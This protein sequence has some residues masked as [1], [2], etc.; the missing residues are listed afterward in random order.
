[1]NLRALIAIA[2]LVAV[3]AVPTAAAGQKAPAAGSKAPV[4]PRRTFSLKNGLRVTLIHTGT[5]K[6]AFV[7][8]VLESGEIDEPAFGPGLASLMADMLLQGTVSR[9]RQAIVTEAA[10]IGTHV[11]VKAGP[12]STTVSAEVDPAN[13]SHLLSLISDIVRHPLLDTASF[14]RAH[15]DAIRALDSTLNHPDA[16]AKQQW[17]AISVTL[18]R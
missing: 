10:S 12:V 17:R 8:M 16:L 14:G 5:D 1:M 9:T 11:A 15:R 6:K 18:D 7:S 2:A 4:L 3:G 13:V